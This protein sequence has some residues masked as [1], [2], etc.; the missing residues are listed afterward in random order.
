MSDG[1]LLSVVVP[2]YRRPASLRR[3]LA[4]LERQDEVPGGFETVIVDDGG[5]IGDDI[6]RG[7]VARRL[8]VRFLRQENAG[9]GTARNLGVREARGRFIANT[10]DDCEPDP[11]WA[12]T[13]AARLAR[14]PGTAFGGRIVDA[15]PDSVYVA[16]NRVISDHLDAGLNEGGRNP[17]FYP[18]MNLAMSRER[19]LELGG[20][21]PFFYVGGEDRDFCVR[22]LERGWRLGF[23]PDAVVVHDRPLGFGPFWR[24]HVNYGR[25]ACR[26]RRRRRE[27]RFERA[28]FYRDLLLAGTRVGRGTRMIAQATL[29]VLSQVATTVGYLQESRRQARREDRSCRRR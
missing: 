21:D 20:F 5:G 10:D 14:E 18:T 26:L 19:F 16:A 4:A 24:Q 12:R 29:V 3:L 15:H 8:D 25:G 6:S 27:V 2:T 7:E 13:L 22:W 11:G 9:P 23:A 1:P 17:R 28:A